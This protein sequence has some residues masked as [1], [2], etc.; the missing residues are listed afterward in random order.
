MFLR[1]E[2]RKVKTGQYKM[3]Q[4]CDDCGSENI[5]LVCNNC[6]SHNIKHP[7]FSDML[8]DDKRGM[9]EIEK[10]K[11]FY[12]CKCD[13][14]G[15]EFDS[16]DWNQNIYYYEGEFGAGSYIDDDGYHC[17][18]NYN[19]HQDICSE[20]MSK[21]IK[22]LNKK[23]DEISNEAFILKELKDLKNIE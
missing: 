4:F 11:D 3:V 20:C 19:L 14:C 13:K 1:K 2:T 12:V 21:L 17:G 10:D 9:H 7:A 22:N 18:K 8:S 16:Y 5:R 15:K 23:L 6:G